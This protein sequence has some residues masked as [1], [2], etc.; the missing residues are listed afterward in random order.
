[1]EWPSHLSTRQRDH[2]ESRLR[3]NLIAWL[4]TVRASGQPECVPVWFLFRDDDT[5]LMYSQ[6]KAVKL[7]NIVEN[8]KV[9]LV[10]DVT[11]IGRDVIR[12]E[13]MAQ[14]VSNHPSA[15]EVP[16]YM[17]KYIERIG[18]LF[19]SAENFSQLFSEPIVITP[20]KLHASVPG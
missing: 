6:P 10:L 5:I 7:R 18:A 16:G 12:L 3:G 11:D 8:P 4:S 17:E 9:T 14:S 1:V 20:T 19:G 2:V 15:Q 13:G